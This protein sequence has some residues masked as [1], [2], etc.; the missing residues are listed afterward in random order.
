M[1][2]EP[3]ET[4][5]EEYVAICEREG[6]TMNLEL[7]VFLFDEGY[8]SSLLRFE[9]Y[10]EENRLF[11]E[12]YDEAMSILEDEKFTQTLDDVDTE[13]MAEYYGNLTKDE[14]SSYFL[15]HTQNFNSDCFRVGD[16]YHERFSTNECIFFDSYLKASPELVNSYP[17]NYSFE[18]ICRLFKSGIT[19]DKLPKSNT[20]VNIINKITSEFNFEDDPKREVLHAPFLGVGAQG[21][22]FRV[23]KTAWKFSQDWETELEIMSYIYN[24]ADDSS[25]LMKLTD[26][27]FY[28][29]V[30]EFLTPDLESEQ[31]YMR[32]LIDDYIRPIKVEF[33]SGESLEKRIESKL[34][35]FDI[36]DYGMQIV[37]GLIELRGADIYHHR[38]I[39]P[40]NILVESGTNRLV[41]IDFGFATEKPLASSKLNRRY[42]AKIDSA[43]DLVSVGQ[44]MYKMATG[45]HLF[46][47][48]KSMERTTCADALRDYRDIVLNDFDLTSLYLQKVDDNVQDERVKTLIKSC[49]FSQPEDHSLI[50]AMFESYRR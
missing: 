4:D 26:D 5:L 34:D 1:S 47:D 21:I 36:I 23:G 50:Y 19:S 2:F 10:S 31:E 20:F 3:S 18:A 11:D 42:G 27:G 29:W 12:M 13:L 25:H 22:L 43:N 45:E 6:W 39:R 33:I 40:A 15:Y 24:F 49:I 44:I 35:A 38:D 7:D 46:A 48:S 17:L 32:R 16:K 41:L 37:S 8:W 14:L 9:P 30:D 28:I